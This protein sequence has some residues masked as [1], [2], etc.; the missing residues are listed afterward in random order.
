MNTAVLRD[1]SVTFGSKIVLE[2]VS[3]ALHAGEFVSLVGASG[4]GKTTLIN[5]IAG[6]VGYSGQIQVPQDIGV[7]FQDYS[8]FPWMTVAN[9]IG[10]GL[11]DMHSAERQAIID[12]HLEMIELVRERDRYPP[13]LS[14]GQMQRVGIARALAPNPRLVMMD[15]PFASLDRHTRDRMQTWL[16]RLWG[17][18][19]S[20]ILFVTHDLDEAIFLS[21]RLLVLT[22]KG[23]C[24]SF[25][26]PFRRPRQEE[27]QFDPDF[28]ELKRVVLAAMKGDT[29][30]MSSRS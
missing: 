11:T 30:V 2:G 25:P 29:V 24:Q 12:Q 22:G 6:F 9:N 27:I 1:V 10:F 20:T 5:A 18:H 13:E 28:V 26:V 14:G 21:D 17:E 19:Q 15:E 4:S 16:L 8:V 7:V 3:L 23:E